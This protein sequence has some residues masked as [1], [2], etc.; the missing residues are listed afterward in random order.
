MSMDLDQVG[1]IFKW[2]TYPFSGKYGENTLAHWLL[3]E[4]YVGIQGLNS[5]NMFARFKS[6]PHSGCMEYHQQPKKS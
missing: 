4:D 2:S 6:T 3:Y 1:T 5:A